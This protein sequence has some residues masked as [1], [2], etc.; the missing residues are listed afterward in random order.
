ME[1][2]LRKLMSKEQMTQEQKFQENMPLDLVFEWDSSLWFRVLGSK[3]I[4]QA[5]CSPQGATSLDQF[6][7]LNLMP[8]RDVTCL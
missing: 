4:P 1:R 2:M 8:F 3:G 6:T 5:S 7:C